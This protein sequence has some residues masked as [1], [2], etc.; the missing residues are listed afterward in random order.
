MDTVILTGYVSGTDANA[1]LYVENV[2]GDKISIQTIEIMP[3]V[4]VSTHASNYITTTISAGGTTLATHT[5]N[6]SGGSAMVAGTLL[7]TVAGGSASGTALEVAS[8]GTVRIVVAKSGT[9]PAYGFA[10][11]LKCKRLGRGF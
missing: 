2:Q 10:V 8:G 3:S 5:T 11:N 1:D 6:S 4:A 9:G 7:A